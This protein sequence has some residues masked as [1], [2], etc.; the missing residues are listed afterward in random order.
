MRKVLVYLQMIES[1]T[2]KTKFEQLYYEYKGLMYF[3]AKKYLDNEQDREDAM[4]MAFEALAKNI[5]KIS[6]VKCPQ[7]YSYIV[8]I[9]E[10]KSIDV[11]RALKK[12]PT[13]E[14]DEFTEGVEIA[15]PGDNGLEDALAQLPARYREVLLLRFGNG[16]N[17]KEI[18]QML[19]ISR[20]TTQT[21]IWRARNKLRII[22]EEGGDEI[23]SRIDR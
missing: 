9:I 17:T 23:E 16:Y 20:G 14:L 13:S 7:T 18:A 21:L 3:V 11:L 6:D 19:G 4:Q 22:L 2:D 1:N 15:L 12:H 10:S 8:N 5:Q